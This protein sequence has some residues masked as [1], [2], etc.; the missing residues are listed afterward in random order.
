MVF[1]AIGQEMLPLPQANGSSELLEMDGACIAV[2]DDRKTSLD[3]V[4]AG[5]DCVS[6]SEDLTVAAVQDGKLAA[7]SIDRTLRS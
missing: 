7:E 3:N 2:N 4:W 5:G 1:K 6:V